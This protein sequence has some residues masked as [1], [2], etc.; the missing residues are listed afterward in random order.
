MD[1]GRLSGSGR[2]PFFQLCFLQAI[3]ERSHQ[4]NQL[5]GIG[6]PRS[7]F[8]DLTPVWNMRIAIAGGH[9]ASS[10]LGEE[11]ASQ[12]GEGSTSVVDSASAK[13]RHLGSQAYFIVCPLN[14]SE[15][16]KIFAT[17]WLGRA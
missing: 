2:F 7:P 10:P 8:R 17:Y 9:Q 1:F 4:L 16:Y 6:F 15:M 14:L 5:L 12:S 3:A 13:V 11:K